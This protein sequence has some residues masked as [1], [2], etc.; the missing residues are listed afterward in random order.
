M[1]TPIRGECANDANQDVDHRSPPPPLGDDE[2][3]ARP[4][5]PTKEDSIQSKLPQELLDLIWKSALVAWEKR[6]IT[7]DYICV[8][9][10]PQSIRLVCE[11]TQDS[12]AGNLV[13]S[14]RLVDR[15]AR[16]SIDH[17][18]IKSGRNKFS[19]C[20]DYTGMRLHSS[21]KYHNADFGHN[22]FWLS[23]DLIRTRFR[24]F[25]SGC[26]LS[27]DTPQPSH[28]MVNLRHMLAIMEMAFT[29]EA[30]CFGCRQPSGTVLSNDP[31]LD[32]HR[33]LQIGSETTRT[34]TLT[35]F[36]PQNI[37]GWLGRLDYEGLEHRPF[38]TSD[39]EK[40]STLELAKNESTR[41]VFEEVHTY[42][43]KLTR[44]AEQ[45]GE[46][47]PMLQFSR[48]QSQGLDGEVRAREVV[49]K[50]ILQEPSGKRSFRLG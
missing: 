40:E 30:P 18:L 46:D 5:E 16:D 34:R 8:E 27:R 22:V 17:F 28:I 32:F 26:S 41:R 15:R 37:D 4:I 1:N 31:L 36:L 13:R 21:F 19:E 47:L 7:L 14:I 2:H 39:E 20:C 9:L 33:L 24:F 49:L 35:A 43:S 38:G 25:T 44:L 3:T 42:W 48:S 23:R 45:R 10:N 29:S 12:E 50:G 6:V 11:N